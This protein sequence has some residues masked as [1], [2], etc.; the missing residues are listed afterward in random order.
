VKPRVVADDDAGRAEAI[1]ALRDGGLVAVPT[2]T[3]YGIA[4]R[5]DTPGG[6][7]A[8]FRAKRRP[9]ERGIV[10][11]LGDASQAS[12]I[13]QWPRAAAALADAFWPGGLTIVVSQ[14]PEVPL[15]D[16]LTGGADTIGLR[17]PDHATPRALARAVGP[18]PTTSANLSG[19]A[20]ARTAADIVEQFGDALAAV[21]D[22]GTARGAIASTVV[23]C[24]TPR[25]T[26]LRAGATAP[27]RIVAVLDAI[28]IAHDIA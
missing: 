27:E 14:R 7:E 18:L 16:A 9:P 24:S 26:I 6:V 19:S 5:L 10:L 13:G 1:Q 25:V 8:L 20:E 22:G 2:D 23:D 12:A 28:G 3:V 21:V 11:L 4:V 17:V 15:P